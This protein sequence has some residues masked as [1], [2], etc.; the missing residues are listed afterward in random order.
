MPMSIINSPMSKALANAQLKQTAIV[1]AAQILF[2]QN[3]YAA[4]HMDTV[5][6]YA[7]VTKQTVYRYFPTKEEL[8]VAVM[9]R[10][11]DVPLASYRFADGT[12]AEELT[13]FG[14]DVLAFHL[15][16]E[17]LG[18]YRLILTEGAEGG[19]MPH[20]M[21][22]GPQRV[23]QPLEAFL[24]QRCPSLQDCAFAAQMFVTML[25]A[26]RNRQLMN[27]NDKISVAEQR[28]HIAKVVEFF[29]QAIA[30]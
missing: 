26:P 21:Q 15:R 13:H 30:A 6:I 9:E 20:F 29:L 14:R 16:D 23:L 18:L 5:A 17:A 8:F 11:R 3:G 28:A 24:R 22:T 19:L 1:E 27:A 2:L 12:L 7:G 4:T 25:L 10:V